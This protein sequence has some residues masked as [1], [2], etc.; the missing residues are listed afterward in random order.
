MRQN[1]TMC[2]VALL[3]LVAL[4]QSLVVSAAPTPLESCVTSTIALAV[5]WPAVPDADLFDVQLALADGTAPFLSQTSPSPK[6]RIVDLNPNT[7]FILTLRHRAAGNWSAFSQL[8]HCTTEPLKDGIGELR[9]LPLRNV[10]GR[11][12]PSW[13]NA[14]PTIRWGLARIWAT[15]NLP[16]SHTE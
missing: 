7:S 11:E 2:S 12:G 3:S 10:G 4:V 15:R 13:A 5:R 1:C 16:V 14:L 8:A 9:S 6:M